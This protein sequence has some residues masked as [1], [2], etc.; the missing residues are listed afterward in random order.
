MTGCLTPMT[1]AARLRERLVAARAGGEPEDAVATDGL[2][3]PP[4]RLRVLVDG[5]ARPEGFLRDSQAA[6]TAIGAALAEAGTRIEDAAPVLD[7]GCG[8]GR[9]ARRWAALGLDLHGCDYN[10]ELVAWCRENLPFMEARVNALEPPTPYADDRFGLVYAISVLTHLTEPLA[11]RWV[12][13]LTRILRPGGLLLVTTHGDGYRDALGDRERSRYDA[14]SPVV[15]RASAEG[16]NAC[17]AYH[18]PR[19]VRDRLFAGLEPVAFVA[20][21]TVPDFV[22]DVH[23]A[24]LPG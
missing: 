1:V 9:V 17:A 21:G 14:G 8:C 10:P 15:R 19:H 2:P 18:P 24:R 3:L 6:A 5:H 7:F 12:E 22:Q 16:L 20:G 4:A 13:E 23:V 11:E